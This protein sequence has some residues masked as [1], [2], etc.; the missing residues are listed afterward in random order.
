MIVEGALLTSLCLIHET[1]PALN[2]LYSSFVVSEVHFLLL[3]AI[4]GLEMEQTLLVPDD[5]AEQSVAT[6]S[7]VPLLSL[8]AAEHYCLGRGE[9]L[10]LE[11][12]E[13]SLAVA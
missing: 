7:F 12:Q 5:F 4:A 6:V 1:L 9:M 8:A 10:W 2:F 13:T 11:E 3:L